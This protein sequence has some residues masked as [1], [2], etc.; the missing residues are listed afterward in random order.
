V[1]KADKSIKALIELII[2]HIALHGAW[3]MAHG[4]GD[5]WGGI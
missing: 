4:V 1:D 3:C 2:L 5:F